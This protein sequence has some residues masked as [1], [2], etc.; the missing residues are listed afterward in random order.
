M[1]AES[2]V[3]SLVDPPL[4]PLLLDAATSDNVEV[5]AAAL[6]CVGRAVRAAVGAYLQLHSPTVAELHSVLRRCTDWLVRLSDCCDDRRVPAVRHAAW[7]SINQSGCVQLSTQPRTRLHH[8]RLSVSPPIAVCPS[9]PS[10][11]WP[12]GPRCVRSL[13]DVCL[14]LW[15]LLLRLMCDESAAIRDDAASLAYVALSHS[16]ATASSASARLPT[17]PLPSPLPSTLSPSSRTRLPAV[18]VVSVVLERSFVWFA[19]TFHC[20]QAIAFTLSMFEAHSSDGQSDSRRTPP[21]A[22]YHIC[23]ANV[24]CH[25]ALG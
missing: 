14:W 23:V 15:Q 6:P 12:S 17:Q 21:A 5:Q 7:L 20:E 16:G 22:R 9:P 24:A 19:S 1:A 11:S 4:W 18:S 10:E 8:V 25:I 13:S 2:G 3:N